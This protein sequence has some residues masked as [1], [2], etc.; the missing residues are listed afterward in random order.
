[1][2][3]GVFGSGGSLV[4]L[5]FKPID[6]AALARKWRLR[7]RGEVDGKANLPPATGASPS[8]AEAEIRLAIEAERK[9]LEADATAH[10]KAQNDALAQVETAMDIA[11]L[12]KDAAEAQSTLR[13]TDIEWQGEI[14][15][16]QQAAREARDEYDEFRNRHRITRPARQP[17]HRGLALAWLGFFIVVESALN[18]VFFAEGS[19]AGLIGGIGVALAV[20]VVNVALLGAVLGYFPAR[21]AHHRNWAIKLPAIL[22]LVAGVAALL[23]VNAF[24][25]H[26]RDAYERLGEALQMPEVWAHLLSAPTDLAR[27]QSW[28]LFLLG[29]GFAALGFG[30]GYHL[31]DPYPGYGA[32]D[33]RRAQAERTYAE[34]RQVRIDDATATRDRAIGNI[35]LAIERLRGAAA[36][37]EQILGARASMVA[38]VA[39][40]EAHLQQAGDTLLAIYRDANRGVRT[41]PPPAHFAE[42][43]TLDAAIVDRPSVQGMLTATGPRHDAAALLQELDRLRTAVLDAYDAVIASAPALQ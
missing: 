28:L 40:H 5:P 21:W 16:L 32:V 18:G 9:R 11:T 25:G 8:A 37:R 34:N 6:I 27:L 19:V 42:P 13:K 15:R 26:Y 20:S 29:L 12:R 10:F 2:P 31:D 22:V 23:I 4:G 7:E 33:R 39:S 14:P 43:F 3:E 41:A 36:Q 17:G 1:M 24:I 38:A 35:E 30:K